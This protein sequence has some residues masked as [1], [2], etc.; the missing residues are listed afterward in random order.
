VIRF[1]IASYELNGR[2]AAGLSVGD[3]LYDM[4]TVL[5]QATGDAAPVDVD[6]LVR[7]WDQNGAAA[8]KQ[9]ETAARAIADGTIDAKPLTGYDLGRHMRLCQ[10]SRKPD[11]GMA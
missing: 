1:G 3:A 5:K 9:F 6:A 11:T 8:V 4:Q 10:G 7:G 2:V